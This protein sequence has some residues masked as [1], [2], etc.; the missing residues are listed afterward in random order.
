MR[1]SCWNEHGALLERTLGRVNFVGAGEFIL[2]S[3]PHSVVFESAMSSEFGSTTGNVLTAADAKAGRSDQV[4]LR[5]IFAVSKYLSS[6]KNPSEA[7]QWGEVK[8][9]MYGEQLA[10][11]AA[12]TVGARLVY[13][14]LPKDVTFRRLLHG[15]SVTDL[16]R[17]FG[18]RSA[19]NFAS[20]L[21]Q[22]IPDLE[23]DQAEKIL[24]TDR[25]CAL[26]HSIDLAARGTAPTGRGVVA[27][28]GMFYGHAWRMS[29]TKQNLLF[30][31]SPNTTCVQARH[32][33]LASGSC[34]RV[35]HGVLQL[36][37]S[38]TLVIGENVFSRILLRPCHLKINMI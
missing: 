12:L 16:D 13:G 32:I 18:H 34:G 26:C 17:S 30:R 4:A 15:C 29:S 31:V 2:A 8:E 7:A 3:K 33:W 1:V 21:G 25:E 19:Q 36:I 24:M 9:K 38:L 10:A 14:D 37:H 28:V 5:T 11:V 27:I 23:D 35:V 20:M 6:L 22:H